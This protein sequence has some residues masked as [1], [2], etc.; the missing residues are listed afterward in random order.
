MILLQNLSYV[1]L[2]LGS[3]IIGH[4]LFKSSRL[5]AEILFCVMAIVSF[6][7][8][9]SSFLLKIVEFELMLSSSLVS[10]FMGLFVGSLCRRFS[11]FKAKA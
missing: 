5:P 2:F 7:I 1:V 6:Y 8:G 4:R 9:R 3:F 10:F 11:L